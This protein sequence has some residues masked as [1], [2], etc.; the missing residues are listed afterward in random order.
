MFVAQQ[1]VHMV[2]QIKERY[3]NKSENRHDHSHETRDRSLFPEFS[4]VVRV[5]RGK[6]TRRRP[7]THSRNAQ[8]QRHG[9]T[10]DP[11]RRGRVS[12]QV[13]QN[14]YQVK[15]CSYWGQC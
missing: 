8:T 1:K 10:E 11:R 7:L 5:T 12:V 6:E 2:N 3:R 9:W 4:D 13:G 15:S 14:N